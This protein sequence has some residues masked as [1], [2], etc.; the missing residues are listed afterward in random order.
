MANENKII[1]NWREN[2]I[3][4]AVKRN[5][6]GPIKPMHSQ[7][8]DWPSTVGRTSIVCNKNKI[9]TILV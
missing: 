2:K 8:K 3:K 9:Y 5:R 4:N 1:G 7:K 6:W